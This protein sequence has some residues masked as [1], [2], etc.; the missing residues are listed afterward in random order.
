MVK[1]TDK[2]DLLSVKF[3]L[4]G[5]EFQIIFAADSFGF[6]LLFTVYC[7]IVR[8]SASQKCTCVTV[9]NVTCLITCM[10]DHVYVISMFCFRYS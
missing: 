2:Q 3:H 10:F 9:C 1:C 4:N 7:S 8:V 5:Y 6:A